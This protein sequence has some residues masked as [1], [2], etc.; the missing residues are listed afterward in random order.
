MC[1]EAIILEIELRLQERL[2]Y[3]FKDQSWLELA[4]THRSVHSTRNNERLEFLGD[5]L[6]G[7][8]ISAYLYDAFPASS[9]GSL[10]RLRSFLVRESTLADVA[11]SLDLGSVLRLGAGEVRTGGFRRD[12]ILADTLEA[13]LAAVFRDSC[14]LAI[15]RDCVLRW[16]GA[17]LL[18]LSADQEVKDAKSRLQ[19]WLQARHSD[20]PEY[21][22]VQIF[23]PD[24]DQHFKVECR[25]D[26]LKDPVQGQ[27]GSRR[28][29]EQ[30]AAE[31]TLALLLQENKE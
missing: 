25:V 29:A 11:R 26:V 1:P 28:Y 4:L 9:E 17:R 15:C 6:L 20:L 3:R 22:V 21:T 13:L 2:G 7:L 31:R 27:G 10:T 30:Q 14:E 12:S 18:G 19:E 16:Y 8:I 24:H 23:G 5:S